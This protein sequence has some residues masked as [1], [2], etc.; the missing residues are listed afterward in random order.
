MENNTLKADFNRHEDI[1]K[2]MAEEFDIFLDLLKS[3]QDKINKETMQI[4]FLILDFE[5]KITEGIDKYGRS[6]S[7]GEINKYS[8]IMK[9]IREKWNIVDV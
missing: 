1:E 5:D 8:N 9:R 7:F 6:K 2:L 3:S 4:E